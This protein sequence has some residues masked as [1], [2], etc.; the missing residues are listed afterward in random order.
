MQNTLDTSQ[1]NMRTWI[2]DRMP[3]LLRP[4]NMQY[5]KFVS[6]EYADYYRKYVDRNQLL[7]F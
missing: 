1:T 7:R 3:P 4:L 6:E 2:S 5:A